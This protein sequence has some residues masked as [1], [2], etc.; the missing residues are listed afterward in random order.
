MDLYNIKLPW[1]FR[2]AKL[3]SKNSSYKQR[4]GACIFKSGKPVSIGFNYVHKSHPE[5]AK[6]FY[7]IHAEVSALLKLDSD[8]KNA[9]MYIYREHNK[10]K[11]PML[12]KPCKD[13]MSAIIA[14]G[15]IKKIYYTTS[16]S[17][18]FECIKL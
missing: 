8:I 9:S 10:D 12:A 17:P 13:C 18:Y 1:Q 5:Y 6:E 14:S 4:V 11:S 3:A 2:M 16:E 15:R 7:S